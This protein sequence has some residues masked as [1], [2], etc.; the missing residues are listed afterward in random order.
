MCTSPVAFFKNVES[1]Q[2]TKE[3][4]KV[5]R[6]GCPWQQD[7]S[8]NSS[9]SGISRTSSWTNF[10][11]SKFIYISSVLIMTILSCFIKSLFM[12]LATCT[13]D[14]LWNKVGMPFFF[15]KNWLHVNECTYNNKLYE[16]YTNKKFSRVFGPWYT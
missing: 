13:V 2:Q 4:K 16:Y 3:L 6:K 9:V 5:H 10:G 14:L 12:H 7:K 8:N 1:C 11:T 15:S